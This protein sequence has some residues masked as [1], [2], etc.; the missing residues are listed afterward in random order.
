MIKDEK[1]FDNFNETWENVYQHYRK[2]IN[3]ELRYHKKFLNGGKTLTQKKV[4]AVFING[5]YILL[6]DTIILKFY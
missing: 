1:Y 4:F 2:K 5:K 6:Q 3:R